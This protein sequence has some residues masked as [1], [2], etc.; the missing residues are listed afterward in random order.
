M[1]SIVSR[2]ISN[3]NLKVTKKLR[4][5]REAP[6][7]SS[8]LLFFLKKKKKLMKLEK[9]RWG[10][11][12]FTVYC[13]RI[14]NKKRKQCTHATIKNS[15]IGRRRKKNILKLLL[16]RTFQW[17]EL[18]LTNVLINLILLCD[19]NKRSESRNYNNKSLFTSHFYE[20]RKLYQH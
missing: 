6:W 15:K 9:E 5:K 19:R 7:L 3:K 2:T 11:C 1:S 8:F 17:L 13:C 4:N 12:A 18:F 14:Y 16:S 10:A 20:G